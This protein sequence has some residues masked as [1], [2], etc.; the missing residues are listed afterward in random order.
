MVFQN[1]FNSAHFKKFNLA[2][3]TV[4]KEFILRNGWIPLTIQKIFRKEKNTFLTVHTLFL[5]FLTVHTFFFTF[6]TV[7]TL[8]LTF[9]RNMLLVNMNMNRCKMS[10]NKDKL[11]LFFP[12]KDESMDKT[13]RKCQST[14]MIINSVACMQILSKNSKIWQ[15]FRP[16]VVKG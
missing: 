9:F 1:I 7:H 15:I 13:L 12:Q 6:L 2:I 8:F 16:A 3:F 11:V 5:T 4:L 10:Y 14:H